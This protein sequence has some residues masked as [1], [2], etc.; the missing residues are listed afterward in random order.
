MD[1]KKAEEIALFRYGL[2]VPFLGMEEPLWGERGKLLEELTARHHQIPF[3]QKMTVGQSTIRRYLQLYRQSGFEALKPRTR[4]DILTSR[5]IPEEL[6]ARAIAIK[7]EAPERSVRKI[8]RI[9][10]LEGLAP[11][12]S[13]KK[14]TLSHLLDR[15]G[16]SRGNFKGHQPKVFGRFEA[17]TP[18]QIWQ[19]DCLHGP[20][21]PD[22]RNP[23][24]SRKTFLFVFLDDFS[25]LV[26][27]A[28]FYFEERLP[29]LENTLKK[30]FLKRGIPEIIYVDNGQVYCSHQLSTI[31]AQ[32]G[33]K[34]I[35]CMPYSPQGKGKVERFLGFVRSDFLTEV[36]LSG[37]KT[38]EELNDLFWAWLEV[39]YHQ[40]P[41]GETKEPPLIR[42]AKHLL[43]FRKAEPSELASIFLWKEK[44]KSSKTSLISLCGNEYEL[45]PHLADRWVEVRF[46]PFDL[47]QVLIYYNGQ[48][49]E[50]A[51]PFVA[52][53]WVH[54]QVEDLKEKPEVKPPQADYLKVLKAHHHQMKIKEVEKLQFQELP[55]NPEKGDFQLPHFIRL[56]ARCLKRRLEELDPQELEALGD[57]W[58]RYG[59]LEVATC[60]IA[61]LK[62]ISDKGSTQH[63]SFYL[64]VIK[65]EQ[66]KIKEES[67]KTP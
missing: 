48:F 60:G 32:L 35:S 62:A 40:K 30:G 15:R 20:H 1:E 13:I 29:R 3:S 12:G 50:K 65:E 41:H 64:E 33:I 42:W 25:R 66:I 4:K 61:L 19:S 49:Y 8:I 21:L 22:P 51:R 31:C 14:S 36:R 67:L 26:P 55:K 57:F 10:E 47:S 27:H 24:K 28:E 63:L 9:L 45:S 56:V 52:K 53:R 5:S 11:E 44:R 6:I 2:I 46:N 18:N 39:E 34:K 54:K 7:E 16:Y 23:E 17:S 38:L 59:P 43:N 58:E 37:V